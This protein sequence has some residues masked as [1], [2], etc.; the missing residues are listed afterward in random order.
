MAIPL[1]AR[2][3]DIKQEV[4]YGLI[5]IVLDAR[6]CRGGGEGAA[7]CAAVDAEGGVREGGGAR[8][9]RS[10]GPE[11]L[12]RVPGVPQQWCALVLLPTSSWGAASMGSRVQQFCCMQCFS[13]QPLA[14]PE[15]LLRVPGARQQRCALVQ[16]PLCWIVEIEIPTDWLL[17]LLTSA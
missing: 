3:Q 7:L 14:G 16:P 2:Q 15:G 9:Q 13:A 1:H 6:V 17:P 10:A 4:L 8:H 5:G 11:G 12:L